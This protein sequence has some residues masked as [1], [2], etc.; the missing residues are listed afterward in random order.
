[1]PLQIRFVLGLLELAA[2]VVFAVLAV[3]IALALAHLRSPIAPPG[4]KN[5]RSA[6][7]RCF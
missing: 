7:F 2:V 5:W 4:R 6:G 3:H 1:M